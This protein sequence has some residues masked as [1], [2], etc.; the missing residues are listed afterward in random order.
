MVNIDVGRDGRLWGVDNA[1][2]V[3]FRKGISASVRRGA[4]WEEIGQSNFVD[5][6]VCTDGHVWAIGPDDKIYMRTMI[7]DDNPMGEAWAA[8]SDSV[9]EGGNCQ[10]TATQITCGGGNVMILGSNNRVFRRTDVTNDNPAG[11]GWKTPAGLDV[12]NMWMQVTAG[13]DGQVWMLHATD[14]NVYRYSGNSY[15]SIQP[16]TFKQINCGKWMLVGV[17]AY[18]EVY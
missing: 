6:A 18:N 9:C 14:R 3:Y 8:V 13:E 2:K 4:S 11:E 1:N 17:T 16:G 15:Q 12:N 5:I 10:N 7:V